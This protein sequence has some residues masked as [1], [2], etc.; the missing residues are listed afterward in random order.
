MPR[1][2]QWS[3]G[4][5]AH[6]RDFPAALGFVAL[7]VVVVALGAAVVRALRSLT[8]LVRGARAC[9]RLEPVAGDLVVLDDPDPVAYA[10]AGRPGRIVVSTAMLARLTAEQ[11]RALIAH[12]AAHLRHR[13]HLYVHLTR[14]AAAANP[15]LRPVVGTVAAGIERWADEDAAVEVGSRTVTAHALVRA[16]G[17]GAGRSTGAVLAAAEHGVVDRVRALLA[18]APTDHARSLATVAVAAVL[19]WAA[20]LA[21]MFWTN[22][23]IQVAETAYR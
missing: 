19:S 6:Q 15:L 9:G 7:A 23:I 22:E 14:L 13:H 1:L 20:A 21:L 12:E 2:G 18:P 11:R 4:A 5:V 10:V 16:A 3:A 17:A 8:D